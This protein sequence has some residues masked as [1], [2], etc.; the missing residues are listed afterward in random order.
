MMYSFLRHASRLLVDKLVHEGS[1]ILDFCVAPC[2][3]APSERSLAFGVANAMGVVEVAGNADASDT[4]VATGADSDGFSLLELGSC[5]EVITSAVT[6][7]DVTCDSFYD[8]DVGTQ[9]QLSFG[10]HDLAS[11][12]TADGKHMIARG[13][14][15]I[16]NQCLLNIADCRARICALLEPVAALQID[17]SIGA[18]VFS[19]D[20]AMLAL[21]RDLLLGEASGGSLSLH[22][23]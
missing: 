4:A 23:S 13:L 17:D 6:H 1:E 21:N 20:D 15:T 7:A 5:P 10:R 2:L 22:G 8:G 19:T 9:T 3:V 12:D 16:A 11:I 18:D 14:A